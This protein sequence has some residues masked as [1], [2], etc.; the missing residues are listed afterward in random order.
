MRNK[1]MS[2]YRRSPRRNWRLRLQLA[3]RTM[4]VAALVVVG[5]ASVALAQPG[6]ARIFVGP[7]VAFGPAAPGPGAR[8]AADPEGGD[9]SEKAFP[10][11][12]PLKTDPEL[13]RLL[14]RA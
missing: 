11:G 2:A 12:A 1:L 7:R 5:A 14:S 10:G 13:E 3:S 9:R 4:M 8:E 6:P